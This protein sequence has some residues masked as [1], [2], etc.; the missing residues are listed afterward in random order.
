MFACFLGFKVGM[1]QVFNNKNNGIAT[2]IID[3]PS[4]IVTKIKKIPV[5]SYNAI[6]LGIP[7]DYE[8]KNIKSFKILK[9]FRTN[10]SYLFTIGQQ[11]PLN[12]LSI[13]EKIKIS[14]LTI[15]K[16]N[17]GNIKQHSFKRGPMSHGSKHHRLQGSLGSGTT[18]GRTFPGK[19]MPGRL[20]N[21]KRTISGIEIIDINYDSNFI[22]VKGCI[23]G[24]ANNLIKITKLK[25]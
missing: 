8:N 2:T 21:E 1:T 19:K 10:D 22:L 14:A 24:K 11:M 7:E 9:E 25:I 18:P 5:N 23:P 12:L 13:G 20:G 4:C 15:G 17:T 6:Q 3:M 16:G